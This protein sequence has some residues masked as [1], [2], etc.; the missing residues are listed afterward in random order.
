MAF[1]VSGSGVAAAAGD[2]RWRGGGGGGGGGRGERRRVEEEEEEEE[3]EAPLKE[4]SEMIGVNIDSHYLECFICIEPLGPPLYQCRNGHVVCFSCW[5]KRDNR[6]YMC[7][8]EGN[9]TRNIWLEKIIESIKVSCSYAKWGCRESIN[10]AQKTAHKETC[11]FAPS[12]C[13]FHG[14]IYK[15]YKGLWPI[16]FIMIHSKTP[17]RFKYNQVFKISVPTRDPFTVLIAGDDYIG[18]HVFLLL[19][20]SFELVGCA[21]SLVCLQSGVSTWQFSYDIEVN[22]GNRPPLQF[23]ANVGVIKEW[24]GVHPTDASL[25]VRSDFRNSDGEFVLDLCI[26]KTGSSAVSKEE[27]RGWSLEFLQTETSTSISLS[28]GG[29]SDGTKRNASVG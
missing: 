8:D 6:C 25:M 18:K 21:F 5:S 15:G 14:C 16:H 2:C 22:T 12:K 29:N 13:P 17:K 9:C 1:L 11:I 28:E 20:N 26:R 3:E 7:S 23:K 24:K 19:H 10:F 27:V 4:R